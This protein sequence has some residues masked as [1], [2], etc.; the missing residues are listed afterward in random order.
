MSNVKVVLNSKGIQE[1]LK[2]PEVADMCMQKAA[3][4][5]SRCGDGYE[6]ESRTYPERK[7]AVIKAVSYTA[8]QDNLKNNT[9]LKAVQQ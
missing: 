2:S 3:S 8:K 4:A 7:G 6:T 9:L 1:M 5:L